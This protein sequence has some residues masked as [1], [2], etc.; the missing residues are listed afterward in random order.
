ML[1]DHLAGAIYRLLDLVHHLLID[2]ATVG[3]R[4]N[5]FP[6]ILQLLECRSEQ[7]VIGALAMA[8]EGR[9]HALDLGLPLLELARLLEQGIALGGQNLVDALIPATS[10]IPDEL[11]QD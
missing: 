9:L 2:G 10:D 4:G 8:F 6:A 1:R 11:P 5:R 7:R 3:Q